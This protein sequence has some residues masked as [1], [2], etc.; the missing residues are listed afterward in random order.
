MVRGGSRESSRSTAS[1]ENQNELLQFLKVVRPEWSFPRKHGHSDVRCVLKKLEAIGVTSAAELAEGVKKNT[2][3]E[4][5]ANAG[6][7][8]FSKDTLDT[9]RKRLGFFGQL[10]ALNEKAFRQTG[11]FAPVPQ[12]L[13]KQKLGVLGKPN[14]KEGEAEASSKSVKSTNSPE[15]KPSSLKAS[16]SLTDSVGN[17]NVRLTNSLLSPTSLNYSSTTTSM[18]S[19]GGLSRPQL[20]GAKPV[21]RRPKSSPEVKSELAGRM[22]QMLEQRNGIR[23]ERQASFAENP[24]IMEET[25]KRPSTA[26]ER[27]WA[28]ETLSFPGTPARRLNSSS[29]KFTSEPILLRPP[30]TGNATMSGSGGGTVKDQGGEAAMAAS[31]NSSGNGSIVTTRSSVQATLNTINGR[32]SAVALGSSVPPS[33]MEDT[34]G[35]TSTS[36]F[37]NLLGPVDRP[38]AQYQDLADMASEVERIQREGAIMCYG[39]Y[40]AP[41]WSVLK[42]GPDALIEQGQAVVDEQEELKEKQRLYKIMDTEG[43]F[44]P[45]RQHVTK[46][47]RHR[48]TSEDAESAAAENVEIRHVEIAVRKQLGSLANSRK[49]LASVKRKLDIG[50]I[51]LEAAQHAVQAMGAVRAI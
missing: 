40:R 42:S 47:I 16:A 28:S 41:A 1:L 36:A 3:N 2:L 26:G 14:D 22:T 35:A 13:S 48:T 20:K 18:S 24:A 15:P 34:L 10:K 9:I 51:S 4:Q 38:E 32:G 12:L 29:G 45:M 6:Y 7:S 30:A 27:D 5:L 23:W 50:E 43:L 21:S 11:P 19:L 17:S 8:V 44:S 31:R 46:N 25:L 33:R 37:G 49:D 39:S